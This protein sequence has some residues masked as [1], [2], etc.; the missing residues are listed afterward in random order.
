MYNP[1]SLEGKTI[2]VT[3]AGGGIGRAVSVAASRMGAMVI[4]VDISEEGMRNTLTQLEGNGH[5]MMTV[6]LS[7]IDAIK[8]LVD[9]VESLDGLVNNAGIPNTCPLQMIREEQFE[10]VIGLN[11]KAPVLLTGLLYKKKKLNRNSSIV[12]TSS[13]A[14]LYTFSPANGLYSLSKSALTSYAKSCAVEFAARGIRSNCV[15]PS[16]V[17][18]HLKESLSF[19]E[20]EYKKDVEK[21]PLKRYA[22]PEEVANAIVFLLSDA[23]SYITG[24]TLLVDGGRSL[25]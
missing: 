21:Y 15:N 7:D 2:L 17:N 5:Q 10:K 19:S 16:M 18:T 6:D 20:E 9:C 25:K 23:S 11:T 13:L 4:L 14:W 3:G 24:H 12:F 22:E 8:K 1:F